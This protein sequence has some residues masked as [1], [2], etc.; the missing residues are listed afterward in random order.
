MGGEGCA[1]CAAPGGGRHRLKSTSTMAGGV[2]ELA[3]SRREEM[4]HLRACVWRGE[5][6][7]VCVCVC[8]SLYSNMGGGRELHDP[9]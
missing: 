3:C 6:V 4:E 7:C 8:V 5:G 9:L 1:G 2:V